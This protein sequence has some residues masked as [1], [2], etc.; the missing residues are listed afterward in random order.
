[1]PTIVIPD[2]GGI[3]YDYKVFK[4][5]PG[6]KRKKG[7]DLV[8]WVAAKLKEIFNT[9]D[10]DIVI[11]EAHEHGDDLKFSPEFEKKYPVSIECKNQRGY[12]H[13]YNDMSQC[14]KN[15]NNK[16]PILVIKSPYK[17]PLVI[18]K[19]DDYEKTIIRTK[20]P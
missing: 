12:A 19:W 15:S 20:D 1:M 17:E 16:T 11:P 7:K 8:E 9:S 18:M 2:Y 13:I 6:Q 14:I 4:M 10:T 5:T 3:S